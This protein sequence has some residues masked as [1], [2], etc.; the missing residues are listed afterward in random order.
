MQH[1]FY[2]VYY[3]NLYT[4]HEGTGIR[5]SGFTI[6]RMIGDQVKAHSLRQTHNKIVSVS[7]LRLY[8]G[9]YKLQV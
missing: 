5:Q 9:K 6:L 3:I 2:I 8:P 7:H 4:K 1:A